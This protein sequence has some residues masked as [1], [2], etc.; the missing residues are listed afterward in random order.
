MLTMSDINCIKT[1]RNKKGMSINKIAKTLGIDWRSAKKYADGDLPVKSIIKKPKG[2]MYEEKWGTMVSDWLLE[3]NREK[4]KKRRTNK[5]LFQ[6]LQ[7]HGFEGSYR[8]VCNFIAEWRSTHSE[9]LPDKGAERMEHPE[10]EAQLD[11]GV[12]EAVEKGHL[13][14]I[15][16]L[17]LSFPASNVAFYEPLPSEN[18]ECLFEGMKKLFSKANGVP[19]VIRIDNM[20]TA[21]KTP[22][23]KTEEAVLT[24]EYQRFQLHYDFQTQVCNVAKGNEKGHVEGKVGYVRYNFF[25][26]PPVINDL[27]D[28]SRMLDEFS[29]ADQLRLHYEKGIQIKELWKQEQA[30]LLAFPEENYVVKKEMTVKVNPYNEIKMDNVLVHVP[31][32]RNHVQLYLVLTWDQYKVVNRDGE[33][34]SSGFRPYMNK[35]RAIPWK[36]ILQDWR[37]KPRI[38]NYSRYHR[39]L[40]GRLKEYF[41]ID[42]LSIRK[43]R[44][45]FVLSL[46]ATHS[47]AEI[48][49]YFYELQ[50]SKSTES[51]EEKHPY[52]VNWGQ[53]D[54]L[55]R[56]EDV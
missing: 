13:R 34:I 5:Q 18:Q 9:E 21:V 22:R 41:R 6:E 28:L 49:E 23:S 48:N 26:V 39:Y 51:Q 31:K 36:E 38:V 42:A 11:F 32:A 25:S 15:H 20:S 47:M 2:M 8:T 4:K 50:E 3:D 17:I 27:N 19:K 52:D 56:Q 35:R 29:N 12:M 24:D 43:E 33:I 46:L 14:D 53:Y 7:S 37:M 40:P 10:G 30:A 16:L 45:D 54:Q 55:A 1:L 44:I